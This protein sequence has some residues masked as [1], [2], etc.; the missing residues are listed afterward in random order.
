M[1]ALKDTVAKTTS[2]DIKVKEY[3]NGM[4]EYIKYSRPIARKVKT[5][6]KATE[7]HKRAQRAKKKTEQETIRQ[8]SLT[9]SYALLIDYAIQNARHFKTFIT[10]TFK[11]NV[12][13]LDLA[14]KKFNEAMKRIKRIYNDF[15]Y[16]G[17][18]EFQKR[19]AVHYH[20]MTNLTI[21]D[22]KV[23]QEQHGQKG[24]YNIKQW[25]HG[26]TSVF[27]LE[28]TD[29]KFSISAYLTKYFYKDIDNR[30]LG[31]KK[32]LKS[33]NVEKPNEKYLSENTQEYE[34]YQ[35]YIE[36]YKKQ[37]K[38]KYITAKNSYAP[39]QAIYTF[40]SK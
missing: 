33:N 19:G 30:L 39:H 28:L 21:K 38:K 5:D 40:I 29:D 24:M 8:D 6:D 35:K 32:I 7:P 1:G 10:L 25:S 15:M 2:Y 9:R 3:E 14:N 34:N 17:V 12:T 26:F 36:K 11:D 37:T 31:R 22:T 16:L 13:D 20:I 23:I 18:P 27:N 4:I